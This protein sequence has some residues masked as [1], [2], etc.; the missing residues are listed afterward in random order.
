MD[1]GDGVVR[2]K[3]AI[4]SRTRWELVWLVLA[5]PFWWAMFVWGMKL[6]EMD[7]DSLVATMGE[8]GVLWTLYQLVKWPIRYR[9]TSDCLIIIR[10]FQRKRIPLSELA[11][12]ARVDSPLLT[13]LAWTQRALWQDKLLLG[14]GSA[15][16]R[17][18]I[19]DERSIVSVEATDGRTWLISP[20]D[21]DAFV[22]ALR[23]RIPS[24]QPA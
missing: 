17:L 7:R 10:T 21:P 20:K 2:F 3:P 4:S 6:F 22:E 8:V 19:T 1:K 9:L 15:R 12:V 5:V 14:P 16:Y 13:C 11:R 23:A 24:P 18:Y